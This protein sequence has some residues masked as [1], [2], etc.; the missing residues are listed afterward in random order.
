MS[1]LLF[2]SL[3]VSL[4]LRPASLYLGRVPSSEGG[5]YPYPLPDTSFPSGRV[6]VAALISL[7][8]EFMATL[9]SGV[10]LSDEGGAA[11]G[12]AFTV[13]MDNFVS[14]PPSRTMF[15]RRVKNGRRWVVHGVRRLVALGLSDQER[16]LIEG[17]VS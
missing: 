1:S 12:G 10:W 3:H 8:F 15:G 9:I 5:K 13:R 16:Q 6:S 17:K 7:S 14:R 2:F 4:G 11:R